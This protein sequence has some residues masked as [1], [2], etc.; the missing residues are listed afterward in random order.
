LPEAWEHTTYES[1]MEAI[2]ASVGD[3]KA[4]YPDLSDD[5]VYHDLAINTLPLCSPRARH[6]LARSFLGWDPVEDRDLYINHNIP[7]RER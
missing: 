3:V 1:A 2:E 5:D 6:Q 4:D 7:L